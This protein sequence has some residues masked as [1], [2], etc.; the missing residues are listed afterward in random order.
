MYNTRYK[1]YGLSVNF[2]LN[3][4]GLTM[5][6]NGNLSLGGTGLFEIENLSIDNNYF[7]KYISR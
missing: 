3:N 7:R 4:S 5:D 2:N 6:S 1:W